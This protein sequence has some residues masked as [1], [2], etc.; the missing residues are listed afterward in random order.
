MEKIF[1]L[2]K[3]KDIELC[4]S[5]IFKLSRR[6]DLNSSSSIQKEM[7]LGMI[8]MLSMTVLIPSTLNSIISFRS[9][10]YYFGAAFSGLAILGVFMVAICLYAVYCMIKERRDNRDIAEFLEEMK[11]KINLNNRF[12]GR[13]E[14]V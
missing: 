5:L 3:T 7:D 4:K 8:F 9:G 1:D 6:Y 14:E 11:L 12:G 2:I 10:S 13:V